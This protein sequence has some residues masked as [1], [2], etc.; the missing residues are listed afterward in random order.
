MKKTTQPVASSR[1]TT[2]SLSALLPVA[3][4]SCS[5]VFML[6]AKLGLMLLPLLL[7]V[8]VGTVLAKIVAYGLSKLPMYRYRAP[9]AALHKW[10]TLGLTGA[11][12]IALGYALA[13]VGTI[14]VE[15]VIT[16]A[17]L[18]AAELNKVLSTASWA[19]S[20]NLPTLDSAS[21]QASVKD[22]LKGHMGSV[23]TFTGLGLKSI[24]L[25][26]L[27]LIAGFSVLSQIL[28]YKKPLA[29]QAP[30][31]SALKHQAV[32]FQECFS[33]FMTAQAYVAL[34]NTFCTSVF[35]FGIL[36]AL[37]VDLP[38]KVLLVSMTFL[39]SFIPA[40]GNIVCNTLM[41]VVCAANGP[42]I[43]ALAI[44]Y[45][46]VAHKAEYLINAHF[47]GRLQSVS[48]AEILLGLVVGETLFGL[49]GLV[50]IPIVYLYLLQALKEQHW[51]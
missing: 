16:Q 11:A 7:L 51:V 38:F 33:N 40:L 32:L 36:P 14:L 12:L 2:S 26:V 44:G 50:L 42:F 45:L 15:Q 39:F 48:V 8:T 47:L 18:M 21:V 34:W 28:A 20:L 31:I 17:P 6:W 43:A 3:L 4:L 13:T 37:E 49:F 27:S 30:L 46:I 22:H 41:A 5:V 9:A 24:F 25:L 1:V 19:K 35:I 10:L 29:D 23:L